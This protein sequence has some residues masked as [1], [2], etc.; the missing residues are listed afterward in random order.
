M[1]FAVFG[2]THPAAHYCWPENSVEGHSAPHLRRIYESLDRAVGTVLASV[3]EKATVFIVSGD[4]VGQNHA[5]W[6]L[7]PD[8]LEKLGY[9][10]K[11]GQPDRD[12]QDASSSPQRKGDVVKAVRDLL[13]KDFRKS[14]ARRLPR[15]LRDRL[16]RRV[17]TADIDWYR[18]RAFCLPT[19]LEGY[20]R[21]N[22]KGRE[23]QGVVEPAE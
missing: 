20:V 22:V 12:D 5:G 10:V 13:P 8:V 23:P 1:F 4:G 16:A 18:T 7:L 19:D 11:A 14:L 17:D 3:D 9:L 2:E 21:L 15:A 6:H